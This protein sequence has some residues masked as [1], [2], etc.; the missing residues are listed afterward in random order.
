LANGVREEGEPGI[1]SVKV[2]LGEGVCPSRDLAI[3]TT[4]PDGKFTFLAVA[5][6]VYCV[7][8]DTSDHQPGIWTSPDVTRVG[9]LTITLGAGESK[10]EVY[11]GWDYLMLPPTATP[12]PEATPIPTP[13]CTDKASF[14]MDVTIP[15]ET[16]LPPEEDF[17]KI[18]RIENIGTCTWTS[19]YSLVL[20]SGYYLGG[21]YSA[22]MLGDVP[23]GSVV[24]LSVD[25]TVPK[26]PG[27]YKSYWMLY[28]PENV[29]FGVGD[30]ANTPFLVSIKTG[31]KPTPEITEWRGDYYDNRKLEGD[32][33]LVR[34]DEEIDFNWKKEAPA[35]EVPADN[36]SARWTRELAFDAG[37]Y[38]FRLRFDDG[39]RL[40]VDDQLVIDEWEDGSDRVTGVD[41]L[42]AKG[43]HDVEV[44]FYD[45][46]SYARVSLNILKLT[47]PSYAGWKG[48][49]WFNPQFG[50]AWAFIRSDQEID[51]DWGGGSPML[52]IPGNDF[53]VR[54]SRLVDF[55]PGVYRFFAQADDGI[56]IYVDGGLIINQWHDS[57]GSQIYT[58]ELTLTG[59]HEVGVEYYE[60]GGN[61]L[62][63]FYWTKA[64]PLNE[65]P[66]A[67]NDAYSVDEDGAL[68]TTAPGVLDND[69]DLDQDPLT[70]VLEAGASNGDVTLNEDGSFTYT[71]N[72]D[73]YGTDSFTYR[74]SD[75]TA[76]SGV[77]SVAIT[78]NSVD[79]LPA[80]VDDNAATQEDTLVEIAVLG[81]DTGLGDTPI[82]V[83]ITDPPSEGTAE[84][85]DHTIQYTPGSNFNGTD[86]FSYTVTDANADSST[87][88][89]TVS[90][91]A[92]N[93][94]P[95]ALDNSYS[96]DED[97]EL[98]VV[99]PGVLGN[100]SDVE[101]G[102]LTAVLENG[103]GNG[104]LTLNA[105]G[106][107]T[108]TPT[109]DFNGADSFT[110][111]AN[112]GSESSSVATVTIDVNPIN[113]TPT[114]VDDSVT[115]E[116]VAPVNID[117]LGNDT[118]LGDAPITIDV[119]AQ[120]GFGTA[121]VLDGQIQYSPG[122]GYEGSD[123][124]TYRVT[125]ANAESST[126]TVTVT[127]AGG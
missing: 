47:N 109:A 32:P 88:T 13:S 124:F 77:G 43:N 72:T 80:A 108:Y 29:L 114:A 101:G 21:P 111:K 104:S 81:N 110:Y 71:P 34:N 31:P 63:T 17:E 16:Y 107:F 69:I 41:L 97:G 90:V 5:P 10:N 22:P 106:S 118:G 62:I 79:D 100:D 125:D 19:E 35:D 3:T 4:E 1:G 70:A 68:N 89:V 56:R 95:E 78:V 54:W 39:V 113:D 26:Y 40:L 12:E 82:S 102:S 73:F 116:E 64:S 115:L 83:T 11:F 36:F 119:T 44:V 33:V 42:M 25:L 59:S 18:W 9:S 24:D 60:H 61:A 27:L 50:S 38:R 91:S 20:I 65:P 55:E 45:R 76:V 92:A 6:G 37:I 53:S 127:S 123:S 117:V 8:V 93:D 98:I 14:I 67:V 99:S 66:S 75:G 105:D 2:L 30:D 126:A 7:S 58:A 85:L 46:G 52:G 112:D 122:E 121:V 49:Y 74:A 28:S 84:V 86:S 96:V 51:F 23:P 48:E 87:A 15:D 103:V 120:P 94:P 57:E